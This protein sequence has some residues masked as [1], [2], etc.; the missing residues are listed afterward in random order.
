MRSPIAKEGF[1]FII[2]LAFLAAVF[3]SLGYIWLAGLFEGLFI[4]CVWFFRDPERTIPVEP[5]TIVSPADGKVVEIVKESDKLLPND[6]Y[7]R[8]S[9]FL[10]VF[11]VHVN[12]IPIAGKVEA[13][14]Y[15][16]GK[17]LNAANH[18]ASLDNEQTAILLNNGTTQIL[19]KQIAG[20][21]A[22]RIVCYANK[23]DEYNIGD[24]FGLIRF[25]SRTDIFVPE[26]TEIK[27]KEGDKVSGASSIIGYLK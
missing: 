21:I 10:N 27:V 7:M 1:I 11:N 13:T 8:I 14:R 16:K 23:G 12:R 24:R 3:Y 4:F 9:I 20:L 15:N 22:R 2:P 26:G 19:V 6:N 25:G 17:F 5:K 18:K